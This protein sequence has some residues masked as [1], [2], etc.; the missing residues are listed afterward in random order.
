M[1][2]S[3][4]EYICVI[5]ITLFPYTVT[6]QLFCLNSKVDKDT[7]INQCTVMY[8]ICIS[9]R[10]MLQQGSP[11]KSSSLYF[12][13]QS[14]H[15]VLANM[16]RKKETPTHSADLSVSRKLKEKSFGM[17][18]IWVNIRQTDVHLNKIHKEKNKEC[19]QNKRGTCFYK[20][21]CCSGC[22]I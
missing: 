18:V 14:E 20:L 11:L 2:L 7:F 4:A 3:D 16:Q 17:Q 13:L 21:I 8:K 22:T 6:Y 10:S 19:E 15:H 1:S 5:T 9:I 12:L